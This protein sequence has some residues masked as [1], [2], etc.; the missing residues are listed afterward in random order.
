V[1]DRVLKLTPRSEWET[2]YRYLVFPGARVPAIAPSIHGRGAR[3]TKKWQA[4]STAT[5]GF[6]FLYSFVPF[7]SFVDQI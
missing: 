5:H 6:T 7:V 4:S 2:K 1:G 3:A